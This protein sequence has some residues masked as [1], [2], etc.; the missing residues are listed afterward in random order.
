V[1]EDEDQI[2]E[3]K[4]EVNDKLKRSDSY[5]NELKANNHNEHEQEKI[6]SG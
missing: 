4:I 2:K 6:V 5:N 1:E 3:K